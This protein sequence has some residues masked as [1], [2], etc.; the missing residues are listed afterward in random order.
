MITR[1]PQPQFVGPAPAEVQAQ[2]AD[3]GVRLGQILS[4]GI[5]EAAKNYLTQKQIDVAAERNKISQQ[6]ANTGA[7]N[8][9]TE[10]DRSHVSVVQRPSG[11]PYQ[12][13]SHEL[14]RSKSEWMQLFTFTAN[15]DKDLAKSMYEGGA[16]A[17]NRMSSGEM[18]KSGAHRDAAANACW[19]TASC[20]ACGH[21][22]YIAACTLCPRGSSSS[23]RRAHRTSSKRAYSAT[24][25]STRVRGSRCSDAFKRTCTAPKSSIAHVARGP[26]RLRHPLF[27]LPLPWEGVSLRQL[28]RISRLRSPHPFRR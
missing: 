18:V 13:W 6:E 1:I 27:R 7:K 9:Q 12:E 4:A 3:Y 22:L 11:R 5:Q 15:G 10:S 19:R 16:G 25:R 26:G 28:D 23:A 21:S 2:G 17:L 24:A 20:C 8:A 14:R